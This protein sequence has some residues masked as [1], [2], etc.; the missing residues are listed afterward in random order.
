MSSR[1]SSHIDAPPP[2]SPALQVAI[3]GASGLI[4]KALTRLL[5]D[6]G[7]LVFPL[8]RRAPNPGSGEIQWSPEKGLSDPGALEG[9][10]AVVHLAGESIASGRWNAQRKQRIHDSRVVGTRTLAQALAGL[11]KPPAVFVCASAVGVYGNQEDMTLTE[12]SPPGSG[13][14]AEVTRAWEAACD[15]AVQAGIRT[16]HLRTGMVLSTSGGALGKMLLP[17]RLGLG[18]PVGHGRQYMSWIHLEDLLAAIVFILQTA[19]LQGP[20]NGT[21]PNPVTSRQFATSLGAALGRP[22]FLPLPALAVRLLFGEMGRELLLSGQRVLPAALTSAGF[23][24]SHP[25]LPAALA[26]LLAR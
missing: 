18:G 12:A 2:S 20:V 14:L 24:F 16:V 15:P 8:V 3:S 11:G 7:H 26:H 17:F 9:L 6:G 4:G 25:V 21:A 13:F 22:A 23:Q 10:D 5:T 1:L 19:S